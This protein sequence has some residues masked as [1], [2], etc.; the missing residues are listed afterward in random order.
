MSTRATDPSAEYQPT[1]PNMVETEETVARIRSHK[2]V[3]AV[4]VM[5]RRGE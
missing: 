3:E 2:G 5:D 4:I 1:Q